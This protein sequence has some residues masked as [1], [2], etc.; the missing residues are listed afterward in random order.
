MADFTDDI[1]EARR[2]T[3]TAGAEP[4]LAKSPF[5]LTPWLV[6]VAAALGLG[7]ASAWWLRPS[8][9][10]AVEPQIGPTGA[11]IA[12]E[13]AAISAATPATREPLAPDRL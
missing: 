1:P 12:S 5:N 6:I 9:P 13:T 8:T 10:K 4:S 11:A 2:E 7:G 3:L